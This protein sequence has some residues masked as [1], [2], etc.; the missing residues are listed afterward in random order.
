MYYELFELFCKKTYY[1]ILEEGWY[2]TCVEK[3]FN[4]EQEAIDYWEELTGR[5]YSAEVYAQYAK[6]KDIEGFWYWGLKEIK[7]KEIADFITNETI[8][9][10]IRN[11]AQTIKDKADTLIKAEI[12][13]GVKE[14][15]KKIIDNLS[16]M[17]DKPIV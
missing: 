1:V 14:N 11:E 15:M 6:P 7:G 3:V 17:L 10:T 12:N 8:A 5:P 2:Y 16:Q 4:T 13:H 9:D